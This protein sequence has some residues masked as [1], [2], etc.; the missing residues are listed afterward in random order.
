MVP[1]RFSPISVRVVPYGKLRVEK[2]ARVARTGPYRKGRR[3]GRKATGTRKL[4]TNLCL[5]EVR[6]RVR[7]FVTFCFMISFVDK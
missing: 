3:L 4:N 1:F 5:Q 7:I 2:F 6:E